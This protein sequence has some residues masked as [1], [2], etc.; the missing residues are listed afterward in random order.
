MRK[1]TLANI[2]SKP[3]ATCDF[4]GMRHS[5]HE[6]QASVEEVNVVGNYNIGNYQDG[7]NFNAIGQRHLGVSWNSPNGSL[8]L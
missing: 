6:C 2:Q 4:C 3:Q 1:L 7:N 5:T 8:K